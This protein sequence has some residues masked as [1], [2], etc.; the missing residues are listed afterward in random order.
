MTAVLVE[1]N[2]DWQDGPGEWRI[3]F[4]VTQR[5]GTAFGAVASSRA[6]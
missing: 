3:S 1:K 5:D 2:N 6:M 4:A